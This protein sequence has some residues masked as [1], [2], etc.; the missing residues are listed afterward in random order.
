VETA[1]FEE[2]LRRENSKLI[3]SLNNITECCAPLINGGVNSCVMKT[4]NRL[5]QM[6]H[7]FIADARIEALEL[8]EAASAFLEHREYTPIVQPFVPRFDYVLSAFYEPPTKN[9]IGYGLAHMVFELWNTN[10]S[11]LIGYPNHAKQLRAI[12]E[13][14]RRKLDFKQH[15]SN[16]PNTIARNLRLYNIPFP[17]EQVG[18]LAK[19][20]YG[21]PS[22]CPALRLGYEVF[23]KIL[24]NL[25]DSGEDSDI[26]DFAHISCVPY[27]D[28]ITLDNRMR[29]YVAQVDQSIGSN[30]SQKVYRN[31]EA[32]QELF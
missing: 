19:W 11:L 20:I 1:N 28:S 32:I 21:T 30:F 22:R 25:T 4:L 23:H 17:I 14:D 9:F 12:L 15:E 7:L 13:A 18:E 2:R 29:G 8:Q 26:P 31:V 6:P 3:Y 5:E 10:R 24:R 16:F 27:V